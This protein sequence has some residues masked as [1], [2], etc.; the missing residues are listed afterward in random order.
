[1][2]YRAENSE[3][4]LRTI[5]EDVSVGIWTYDLNMMQFEVSEGFEKITGYNVKTF[6]KDPEQFR[7]IIHP[8]D[9]HL[10]VSG[11]KELMI[12]HTD[13]VKEY[14]IICSNGEIKWVQN[15]GRAQFNH[16][17]NLTRLEGVLIDITERKQMEESIQFLAYHDELTGLPNRTLLNIRFKEYSKRGHFPLAVLFIDLDNFKDVNDTYGHIVGDLLL[18]DIAD[19]MLELVREQDTVCRLG[20]DEFV[21]L[22]TEMDE[23]RVVRVADRIRASL[24]EGFVY[25]GFSLTA[26]ASIGICVSLQGNST[27]EEM[28]Q[29]ADGAM[30]DAKKNNDYEHKAYGNIAYSKN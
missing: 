24:T 10:F 11:Q 25:N 19:R 16:L 28:I 3:D 15:R 1:M 30:Y 22:L 23:S 27:L 9:Q 21:V 29:Q 5:L 26:G 6:R 8:D 12:L 7:A 13:M 4:Q 2:W 14:R 20:G 18:K 17:N